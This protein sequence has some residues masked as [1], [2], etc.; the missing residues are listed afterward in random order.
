[1]V[2]DPGSGEA[3]KPKLDAEL[4]ERLAETFRP[5][6][7]RLEELAGRGFGWDL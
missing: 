2:H 3:P 7:A 5:D 6:A 1:V 4:R